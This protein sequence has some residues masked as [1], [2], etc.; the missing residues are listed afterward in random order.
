[1]RIEY[2][3]VLLA[4]VLFPALRARDRNIGLV[5]HPRAVVMAVGLV[6]AAFWLW[7]VIATARGH[8]SWNPSYVIGL[9]ILDMPVEE[10]LFFPVVCFVS[11][12]TWESVMFFVK[13]K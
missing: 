2:L 6:C 3:L 7:D 13:R 12:F 5:H 4:V 1:M 9:T 10:W 11:I 8:W